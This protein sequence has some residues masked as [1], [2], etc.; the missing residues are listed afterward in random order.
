M[1]TIK[2]GVLGNCGRDGINYLMENVNRPITINEYK[3]LNESCVGT[4]EKVATTKEGYLL[5]VK[6]SDG[7]V[8]AYNINYISD[9]WVRD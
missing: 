3:G 9:A 2:N 8:K 7:K 6:P 1:I 5:I 4:L